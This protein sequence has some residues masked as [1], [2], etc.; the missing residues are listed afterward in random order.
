M[1]YLCLLAVLA[2]ACAPEPVKVS[3]ET[4]ICLGDI[5]K[6]DGTLAT[7]KIRLVLL[8][9][10]QVQERHRLFPGYWTIS[11]RAIVDQEIRVIRLQGEPR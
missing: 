3:L 10:C 11:D 6:S 7:E 4:Q 2:A 9:N 8:K 5:Q 1:K